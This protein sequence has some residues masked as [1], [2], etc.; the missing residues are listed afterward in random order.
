G[1]ENPSTS[2]LVSLGMGLQWRNNN[3]FIARLDWGI[4]LT[5]IDS[6]DRTWQENG[7]LF[8][9]QWSAF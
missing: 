1:I 5:D 4:P 9:L 7:L 8:S 2:T 6:R 3:D